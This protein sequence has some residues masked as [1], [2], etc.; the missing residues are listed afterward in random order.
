MFL[1][2][3]V[4]ILRRP[5]A[6]MCIPKKMGT[7]I[8]KAAPTEGEHAAQDR[9]NLSFAPGLGAALAGHIQQQHG[10]EIS[11]HNGGLQGSAFFKGSKGLKRVER[12]EEV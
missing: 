7:V 3:G 4:A 11:Q 5:L 9:F 2:F 10:T 12:V 6:T 8:L 1:G